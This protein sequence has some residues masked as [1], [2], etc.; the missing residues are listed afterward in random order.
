M[1][2]SVDNQQVQQRIYTLTL[3]ESIVNI[4]LKLINETPMQRVVS[5]A[6]L[7]CIAP[8]I[9]EQNK[10]FNNVPEKK[11]AKKK[12]VKKKRR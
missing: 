6:M 4:I 7:S 1:S 5:D 9:T 12:T 11:P 10:E 2:Q 8:Q 3:P